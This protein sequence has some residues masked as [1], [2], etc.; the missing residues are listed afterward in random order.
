M[1][2]NY[3]LIKVSDQKLGRGLSALLGE[4]RPK[5]SL[6]NLDADDKI[7]QISLENI[8]A[9]AFQP[10]N[11]FDEN[12]LNELADSIKAHGVIQPIILAKSKKI[13]LKLTP[14]K[15]GFELVKLQI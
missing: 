5:S 8:V 3:K 1:E 10:R 14:G 15:E 12:D 2:Q 7:H 11:K 13:N 4:S 9:G 6:F